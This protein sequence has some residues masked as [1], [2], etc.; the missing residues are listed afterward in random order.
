M[1]NEKRRDRSVFV[2]AIG[3]LLII[4]VTALILLKPGTKDKEEAV[5]KVENSWVDIEKERGI[6]SSEL[7][8]MIL[9]N[10][11]F[12]LIDIRSPEE[13]SKE[14]IQNSKNL[15]AAVL[16]DALKSVDKEK[17]YAIVSNGLSKEDLNLMAGM[18]QENGIENFFYLQGGLAAWKN[19]YKPTVSEGDPTSFTDQAKVTYIKSGELNKLVST[20]QNL[21]IIDLRKSAQFKEGHIKNS[22]NIFLDNLENERVK[23]FPGKKIVLYD[24]NGLWAFKGAVRLYDLGYFNVLALSD[25]L[26]TWKEKGFEIVK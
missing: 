4:A 12:V 1:D 15:P 5:E 7:S 9:G 18:F 2:V 24:N 23:I 16:A 21:F 20:D 25:G 8:K 13:F 19:S 22:V 6:E 10:S 14:H 3:F 11:D 17:K 26:D